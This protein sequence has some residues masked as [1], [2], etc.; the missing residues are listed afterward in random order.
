[1]PEPAREPERV[2]RNPEGKIVLRIE[3]P[4]DGG[5][6]RAEYGDVI[7]DLKRVAAIA[8]AMFALLIGLSFLFR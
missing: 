5:Q 8:A 7:A 3:E 4:P 2:S 6:D 1:M